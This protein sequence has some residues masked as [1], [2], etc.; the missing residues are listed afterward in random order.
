MFKILIYIYRNQLPNL[1]NKLN[2]HQKNKINQ[3]IN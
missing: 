2:Y 3:E 1:I